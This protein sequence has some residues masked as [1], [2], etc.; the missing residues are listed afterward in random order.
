MIM[1]SGEVFGKPETLGRRV[2][3]RRVR[4]GLTQQQVAEKA[5]ISQGFLS[6]IENDADNGRVTTLARIAK[7]LG[8][9]I[10]YLVHG[11]AAA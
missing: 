6:S 7:V 5:G 8:V 3:S 2:A 1:T 9:T 11:E 10:D 4:L